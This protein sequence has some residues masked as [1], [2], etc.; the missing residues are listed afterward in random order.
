MLRCSH[1]GS[2]RTAWRSFTIF[3]S[4]CALLLSGALTAQAEQLN[5][6]Q[7]IPPGSLVRPVFQPCPP[8]TT[9][10][11]N[12]TYPNAPAVYGCQ[13][14]I[15]D[16][17]NSPT[18][19]AIG[20]RLGRPGPLGSGAFGAIHYQTDHNLSDDAVATVIANNGAPTVRPDGRWVYGLRGIAAGEVLITIEVVVDP[21]VTN[22]DNFPFGVVTAYCV[23]P[24]VCPEGID[25]AME[26]LYA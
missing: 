25:A 6:T 23:G 5:P 10:Y 16:N 21:A 15:N 20:I 17:G 14:V 11:P 1:P 8:N 12:P 24:T 7:G 26:P 13:F 19:N 22:V 9:T 18:G 4:S 2:R 3:A